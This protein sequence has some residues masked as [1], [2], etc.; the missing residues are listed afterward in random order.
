MGVYIKGAS[1]AD[2]EWWLY[3]HGAVWDT[4]DIVDVPKPHGRLIDADFEEAHYTSMT[5][6]PTPDV[7]QKDKENS[8]IIVKALQMA[9]TVIEREGE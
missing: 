1:K 9:R 5:T 8:L 6:K 7:S 3:T 4:R 2:L